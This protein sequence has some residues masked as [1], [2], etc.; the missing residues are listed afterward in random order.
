MK[1]TYR[2]LVS[3]SKRKRRR[4]EDKQTNK[5]TKSVMLRIGFGWEGAGYAGRVRK[6]FSHYVTEM[7]MQPFEVIKCVLRQ[8]NKTAT[9]G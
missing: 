6:V 2:I 8:G 7:R 9:T 4:R 1:N 5:Q 3:K